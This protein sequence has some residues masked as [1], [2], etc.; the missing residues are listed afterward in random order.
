MQEQMD[1]GGMDG[2]DDQQPTMEAAPVEQQQ[3]E[4]VDAGDMEND[5]S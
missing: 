2:N 4:A 3:P 1:D 5:A